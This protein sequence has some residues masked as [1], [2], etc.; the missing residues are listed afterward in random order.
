[1]YADYTK[2]LSPIRPSSAELDYLNFQKDIDTVTN[3]TNTWLM[4]LHT[5][6]CKVIHF[7]KKNPHREYFIHDD[8]NLRKRLS[9]TSHERDLGVIVSSD[10]K[11]TLHC[12]KAAATANR[13]L[14]LMKNTFTSRDPLLWKLIYTTYIRPHLEFASSVWNPFLQK[15]INTLE[16]V[17]RRATRIP[18]NLKNLDYESRC[19]FL[20]LTSLHDRRTRGDLIQQFKIIHG[21]DKL[22]WH[23]IPQV[24]NNRRTDRTKL[25]RELNP[26]SRPRYNFFNNRIVGPWNSLPHHIV[27]AR[28]INSFKAKIDDHLLSYPKYT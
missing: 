18:Y 5:G 1:M 24:S 25:V 16:K 2:I 13:L 4:K 10:L 6:K 28:S 11:P 9:N 12:N 23:I 8:L 21:F 27:N 17:Q 20:G 22:N 14:G 15:D 26:N 3:W 19:K 7:G